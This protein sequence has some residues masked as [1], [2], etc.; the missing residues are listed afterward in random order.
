MTEDGFFGDDRA[1]HENFRMGSDLTPIELPLTMVEIA[2]LNSLSPVIRT[3]ILSD[4]QE[5]DLYI[6]LTTDRKVLG[7]EIKEVINEV[8]KDSG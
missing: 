4:G 8:V 1:E 7:R 3:V 2:R 5:V 6:T